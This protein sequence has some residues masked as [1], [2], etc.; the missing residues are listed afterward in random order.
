MNKAVDRHARDSR[1]LPWLEE[2]SHRICKKLQLK[3][4]STNDNRSAFDL[5]DQKRVDAK[6][7]IQPW[8]FCPAL[9]FLSSLGFF[10]FMSQKTAEAFSYTHEVAV[11]CFR[12]LETHWQ[13]DHAS[14]VPRGFHKKLFNK[15][16]ADDALSFEDAEIKLDNAVRIAQEYASETREVVTE[17]AANLNDFSPRFQ[18][19]N[20][21]MKR[22]MKQHQ[23]SERSELDLEIDR[24]FHLMG[25]AETA[26]GRELWRQRWLEAVARRAEQRKES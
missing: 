1:V 18:Q 2:K 8:T 7:K 15:F 3:R 25:V 16:V 21:K 17:K 6:N 9:D 23:A 24:L 10:I 20:R 22:R 19:F 26:E 5:E 12:C 4:R 13:L 14:G 11:A